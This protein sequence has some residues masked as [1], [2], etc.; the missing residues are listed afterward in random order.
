MLK[1][2]EEKRDN[3][4]DEVLL[5]GNNVVDALEISLTI[6]KSDD[7]SALKDI[8]LS[9]KKL[10]NKSNE[11]DNLIVTTLALYSPEAKDLREM[12]SY[13]KITNE[14]VRAAGN[15]KGFIKI[16]RKAFSDDLDT[17]TI[18][19][20]TIPLHKSSLLA[21]RTSISMIEETNDKHTEDKYQ[22]VIVEE[23][24]ADDLYAMVE[25]NILKL[26]TKN[27]ELSKE[28]FDILSSLRKL[29]RTSDRASSIASLALFAQIGGDI[30]QS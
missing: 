22:R 24:K 28:Y 2:Y 25:K 19:E 4:K 16:F 8:D 5:I 1:T 11:I 29:E 27:L 21:L 15:V 17:S 3:I 6:L 18:L 20:Y 7:I 14:L 13:L 12:V 10:S 23:S 26:I 30:I 9:V